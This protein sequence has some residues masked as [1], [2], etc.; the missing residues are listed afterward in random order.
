MTFYR[1]NSE[2]RAVRI[3]KFTP[4]FDFNVHPEDSGTPG[5]YSLTSF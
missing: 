4:Q 5:S 2:P 3:S 1:G